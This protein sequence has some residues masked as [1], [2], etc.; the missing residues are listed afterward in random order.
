MAL[1]GRTAGPLAAAKM[2]VLVLLGAAAGAHVPAGAAALAP[3]PPM[4]TG[5]AQ[6]AAEP[7]RVLMI[8]GERGDTSD[9]VGGKV[10]MVKSFFGDWIS[11][12]DQNEIDQ[13]TRLTGWILMRSRPGPGGK[14]I[15]W[16]FPWAMAKFTK[17]L[18]VAGVL[19]PF[20][21]ASTES[22]DSLFGHLSQLRGSFPDKPAVVVGIT[23]QK[24][25]E[26]KVKQEDAEQRTK[27]LGFQYIETS[28]DV[29][30][31]DA[32]LGVNHVLEAV[33]GKPPEDAGDE[34]TPEDGEH[35][36]DPLDDV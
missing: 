19:L 31:G 5:L 10:T 23:Q 28:L 30:P 34:E 2:A 13:A 24:T 7:P 29:D 20:D 14:V 25:G 16:T 21:V 11:K 22:F 17:R 6:L 3:R 12:P 15:M 35:G 26:R 32:E 9:V 18:D 36:E 33:I 4:G 27:D 1:A 8:S